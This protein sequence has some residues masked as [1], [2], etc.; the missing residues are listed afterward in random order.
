M[1]REISA[2]SP[3]HQRVHGC[4]PSFRG[5]RYCKQQLLAQNGRDAT[6]SAATR[7]GGATTETGGR[8][9]SPAAAEQEIL[10]IMYT[11]I[12]SIQSKINEFMVHVADLE[13]DIILL[14]ETWCNSS[15]PDAALSI[16]LYEIATDLRRDRT[17]TTNG[18]GG[19]LL[20]YVKTGVKILPCDKFSDYEFNQFCSFKVDTKGSPLNI[21]LIYRPPT[22]GNQNID[23]L[24]DLLKNLDR[25]SIVI[26]DVNLPDINW[27]DDSST[28]RGRKVLETTLEEGL[29][30][31]VDFPTHIKGNILDL[32]ITNCQD[33]FISIT[34]E[35]RIG[36]SDHCILKMELKIKMAKK[37]DRPTRPNWSK[38]D[39]SGLKSHLR[40]I[41]W[42]NI[43]SAKSTE[44]TWNIFK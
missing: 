4:L 37:T 40:N 42:P 32:I 9:R 22:S 19:G 10:K 23:N 18:V 8:R 16:P 34:D 6:G 21:V 26:G 43:F 2:T 14:T 1:G 3:K 15:I 25:N 11:N 30:Q 13:P 33:K 44:E 36:K 17:D 29:A 39:I 41:D 27:L 7:G 31:L 28:S 35:G 5:R 38:A 20:V 24:C 12:Q